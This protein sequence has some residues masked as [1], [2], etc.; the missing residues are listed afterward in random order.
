M[1]SIRL[2]TVLLNG[3]RLGLMHGPLHGGH[4]HIVIGITGC[5]RTHPGK[6]VSIH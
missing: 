5:N 3:L 4:D 2:A 1:V 6:H